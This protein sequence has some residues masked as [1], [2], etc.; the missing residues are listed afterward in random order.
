M[1][2]PFYNTLLNFPFKI[3]LCVALAGRGGGE[4]G[5]V[6]VEGKP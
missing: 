5:G 6:V 1:N 2:F 4:E 3:K